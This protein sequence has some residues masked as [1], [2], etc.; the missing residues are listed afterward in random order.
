MEDLE[1]T[2]QGKLRPLEDDD[3][4]GE[5]IEQMTITLICRRQVG[6]STG[7]S[8]TSGHA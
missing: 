4:L 5:F 6:L 2:A 3:Q 1:D 7:L 8:M